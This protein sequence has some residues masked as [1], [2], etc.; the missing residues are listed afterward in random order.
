MRLAQQALLQAEQERVAELAKTNQTL[1]NSLDRLA[2]DPCLDAFLGHVLI[3]ISQQLDIYAA[4]LHL[5]DPASQ[6]LQVNNWV[7]GSQVL[8]QQ[9]FSKLGMIS[10]PIHIAEAIIWEHLL[11]SRFPFVIT[12]ANAAQFMFPGTHDWQLQWADEHGVQAGINILLAIGDTPLGLLG[13]L[14][15]KRSEFT[16]EELELAQ[17]LAH[18]ATLAVQLTRLA[19]EAK[20]AAILDERNRLAREI[21]D[22]LA[23]AFAGIGMQLQA[24]DRFYNSDRDK[25]Q[26]HLDRAQELA[27]R[28]LSEA[29]RSVWVLCQEGEEYRDLSVTLPRLVEQ[30]SSQTTVQIHHNIQGTP[31]NLEPEVGMNLLRIVQES[32]NNALQHARA[33][34]IAI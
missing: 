3:E 27:K 14:S 31:Y 28:G 21:H 17:A 29:R 2:T 34:T 23:Q 16:C 22:T 8:P 1:K 32:L 30:M 25:A 9:E 7:E 20:Q 4:S 15:T 12:R 11:Q 19:E 13:L 24:A 6:T 5:Y 33:P 10:A 18:Q 26:T